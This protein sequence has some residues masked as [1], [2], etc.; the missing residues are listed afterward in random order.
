MVRVEQRNPSEPQATA[1]ETP[2]EQRVGA[3]T[4]IPE[5]IRQLGG[6]PEAILASAGLVPGAYDD[7]E[8]HVPYRA[9][10]R[11]LSEAAARTGCAHFGLLAGRAWQL[12][13]FGVA[14]EIM[15][16]SPTVGAAL[17]ALVVHQ[18][19]NSDGALAFL[20]EYGSAV[21]LGYAIYLPDVTGGFHLYDTALACGLCIMRGLCG[22][23][24][25]PAEVHFP[26]SL[27][28]DTVPYRRWFKAPL[29][30]NAEFGALRFPSSWMS[31][32]IPG[33]DPGRLR[34]A[35]KRASAADRGHLVQKTSRALRTLLLQ[36]PAS[37]TDV[38]QALAM[39]RRTLNRRLSAEGTTFQEILDTVRFAVAQDLLRNSEV[40]LHD[41]AAALGYAGLTPF[42][43]AFRR[44]TGTSP[45]HWRKATRPT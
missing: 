34:E 15:R 10:G 42:M 26:H 41:I 3:L 8:G 2:C 36:G 4:A 7:P 44:W 28:L 18:H 9:V 27:P 14:G 21:D 45:G 12:T 22:A 1:P 37:G 29:R 32:R 6:D 30:F 16:N 33:A 31:E 19:L 20:R 40:N 24:W 13:D 11:T 23:A 17:Q 25:V 39:H 35:Q 5:L 38:A 43:R